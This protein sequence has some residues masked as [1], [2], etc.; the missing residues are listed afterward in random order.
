MFTGTPRG[1]ARV[2]GRVSTPPFDLPAGARAGTSC[3]ACGAPLAHDQRYCLECGERA[4]ELPP[5]VASLIGTAL[6]R[7]A[8]EDGSADAEDDARGDD[9]DDGTGSGDR[10]AMV[11]PRAAAIAVLGVLAFGSMLGSLVTPPASSE[12]SAPVLIA[13]APAPTPPPAQPATPPATSGDDAAT[14]AASG[15]ATTP[16][17]G[18]SGD[19]AASSTDDSGAATTDTSAGSDALPKVKHVFL[20]MLNGQGYD[21]TYG[22]GSKA[23][24]LS[25]TLRKQGE[26]ITNYYAATQGELANGIALV[27][28]QGPTAQTQAN[29]PLYGDV[30]PGTASDTDGQATGDGCV[31]P[32]A[33]KTLGDQ[34]KADGKTWKAYVEDQGNGPVG[35]AMTC[36]HPMPG[37]ADAEMVARPG[38]AYVTWRNPFV[39]FH[40]I[41]DDTSSCNQ[42][43]V[44]LGQLDLD[45]TSADTTPSVSYIVPNRCHDGSAEACAPGQPSGLKAAD[46]WLKSEIPRIMKSPAYRDGG[47]IAITS[48]QAP[49]TGPDADSSSCCTPSA[50]PNLAAASTTAPASTVLPASA[51]DPASTTAPA[52]ATDPASTVLPATTATPASS[53]VPG[54]TDP[55]AGE[56]A[57][58]PGGGKVGLLL[59]SELVKAGSTNLAD[60]Y[61]HFSLLRSIE[62]LFGLDHLGYADDPAMPAFDKVVYNAA[63]SS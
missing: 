58:S 55:A 41:L 26:L 36:R 53:T 51:T 34:L 14:P 48:D 7:R 29:C 27:S 13:A 16:A 25:T 33:V 9:P 46:D 2:T 63:S 35:E 24:Y 56:D 32:A 22:D 40:S 3:A 59:V 44:A 45:L 62:D 11:S 43:D 4:G 54:A 5:H 57:G 23:P 42:N 52:S 6:P 12:A 61:N 21:A 18:A 50:F 31:Y 10:L 30:V 39:Y 15:D 1:R 38:D 37:T 20:V 60:S 17:A 8:A 28:G 49:Q 19:G 47:L